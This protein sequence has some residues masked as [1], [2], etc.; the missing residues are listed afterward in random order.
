MN[1]LHHF[2]PSLLKIPGF[3]IEFITP[4]IKVT[5]GKESISFFTLPEYDNWCKSTDTKGWKIK[6]YKGLGTSTSAEAK[7][8]FAAIKQHRKEFTWSGDSDGESLEMAFS[9]KKV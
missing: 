7:D 3:L 2:Y 4:I 1:F 5:K 6:Y 9:K 8:Y